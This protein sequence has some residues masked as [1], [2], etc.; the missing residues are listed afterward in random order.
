MEMDQT[1]KENSKDELKK[2]LVVVSSG[3]RLLLLVQKQTHL[4]RLDEWVKRL[5]DRKGHEADL[6]QFFHVQ[7]VSSIKNKCRLDHVIVDLLVVVRFKLVPF[8]QHG[9][10]VSILGHFVR[11]EM[12]VH[13]LLDF[14]ICFGRGQRIVPLELRKRKVMEHLCLADLRII[15]AAIGAFTDES[16]NNVNCRSLSRVSRIFLERKSKNGYLLADN[17]IEHTVDHALHESR[18]LPV[19]HQNNGAPVI[20]NFGNAMGFADVAQIEDIFLEA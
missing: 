7:D 15:D 3:S 12:H 11:I 5:A 14:G 20:G 6:L 17:S 9:N 2:S 1:E 16:M 4:G 19:V 13:C 18:L 8:C 10:G